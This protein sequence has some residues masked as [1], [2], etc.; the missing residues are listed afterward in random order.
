MFD[1]QAI[2][3]VVDGTV[4]TLINFVSRIKETASR[5]IVLTNVNIAQGEEFHMLTMNAILYTSPYSS[6]SNEPATPDV[7]P[8]PTVDRLAQLKELLACVWASEDWEAAIEIIDQILASDPGDDYMLESLYTAHVNYGYQLLAEEDSAAASAQCILA[9]EIKPDSAEAIA[10]RQQANTMPIPTVG[11][12]AKLE[13]RLDGAW[14]KS[15]WEETL[16]LIEQIAALSPDREDIMEK[17]YAAHISYGHK[18][19][20]E[21]K[22]VE[23][24]AEF[25]A[26]LT[27][28]PDG[29]EA[30][31]ALQEL[32][33]GTPQSTPISADATATPTPVYSG[34]ST[35]H[36]V[37][38]VET[39]FRIAL[40]C[41]TT[42]DDPHPV[43]TLL[44]LR[45]RL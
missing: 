40:V 38:P 16:S 21:G 27:V 1:A 35:I 12:E 2:Q 15:D 20:G 25:Y 29:E 32:A 45:A 17:L 23:A 11:A 30:L 18:L 39:L 28:K 34:T 4:P 33:S 36:V 8:M 5:S 14:A 24:R 7:T 10:G 19:Q 37:R 41:G 6:G 42:V 44:S 9:L 22:L 13:Q 43:G 31:T 3:L 26:A